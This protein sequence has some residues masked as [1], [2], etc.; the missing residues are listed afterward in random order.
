M[1]VIVAPDSF[2]GSMSS[3]EAAAS[4]KEGL[5]AYDPDMTVKTIPMADGGEG[6]VDALLSI[7]GGTR[8]EKE[9]FDPLGREITAS[10]GWINHTKTAVVE[11]AAASGL[12]L[13]DTQELNPMETSTYGTGQLI[14][15]ALERG[16]EKIILGLGGSATVDAGTGCFQ[17]LG[18]HF[19]NDKGEKL[20]MCGDSLSSVSNIETDSM[21]P[22]MSEVEWTIA[23]DVTNP[24]LGEKG[25]VAVFGPQ[26]GVT[27]EQLPI[28]EQKMTQYASVVED[29]TTKKCRHINGSGAA[30]GFGFTLFSL[31][32]QPEVESGFRLIA[33][34][35]DLK[36]HLADADLVITGE[37]KMDSQS[38]YGKVPV[39]IA[40]MAKEAEVPCIALTGKVEG[41]LVAAKSEGL[42]VI[43]PIVDEPMSLEEAMSR[44]KELCKKASHRFMEVYHM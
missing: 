25:A 4:I 3:T 42:Q 16:A 19:L 6:T 35:S 8:I 23:S 40:Q 21:H 36:G 10:Y 27:Q 41:D 1:K 2:K 11:T 20:D 33:E 18:V 17:A 43:L 5:Q 12:P 37:G 15:D 28:F 30:G 32:D 26:K 31:L 9:V 34:W 7:L 39:G 13:L 29:H 38:L 44:G 22:R 14:A 24:L